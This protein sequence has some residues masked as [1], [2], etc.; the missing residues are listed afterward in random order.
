MG[1]CIL[2]EVIA[3]VSGKG[4]TGKTSLC[5]AVA[6]ILA[7]EGRRVLCIDADIGLRNLDIF[8]GIGQTEALSF[9]DIC[10]GYYPLRAALVHPRFPC[11]SF[12]TAPANG[13]I[14]DVS[15]DRLRRL[16]QDARQEFDYIFLDGPSGIGPGMAQ[17][18]TLADRCILTAVPDP[19][20]IRCAERTGQ[21][22]EKLGVR[23]VRLVLQ[24]THPDLMKALDMT[25]DDVMDA[26]GL[27]LL[28]FVPSDPNFSFAASKAIPFIQFS[29]KGAVGACQRIAKRIQGLPAPIPTR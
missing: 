25:I 14:E 20:S 11:L 19:A 18:V 7:Q 15:I 13:S 5:A 12:L 17:M 4:G 26:V 3:L 8:L 23:N 6:T 10:A 22:L 29:R 16:L 2:G 27:P 24:R 1:G 21:E 9:Q 28:G